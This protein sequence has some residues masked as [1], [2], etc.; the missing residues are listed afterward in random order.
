MTTFWE[1]NGQKYVQVGIIIPEKLKID[2]K[3]LG[4]N[5]TQ[6]ASAGIEDAVKKK[7][8]NNNNI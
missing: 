4:I 6:A 3:I 5:L 7:Q 2:A 8:P 1:R